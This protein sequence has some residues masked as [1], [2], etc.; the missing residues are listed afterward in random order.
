MTFDKDD[1][2]RIST[3]G[4]E[5]PPT[6]RSYVSASDALNTVIASGYF[7]NKINDWAVNDIVHI[8]ASDG[9]GL[10]KVTS[11]TTNVT[12]EAY[13]IPEG[14]LDLTEGSIFVGDGSNK[15][16]ELDAKADAQLLL[17][18]GT[19]LTSVAMSGD[20]NIDNAGAATIQ[21][22]AVTT[23]KILDA[24][25][26]EAKVAPNSLTGTVAGNVGDDSIIGGIPILFKIATDGGATGNKDITMTHKV[27]ILDVWSVNLAAGTTSDTVQ[28]FNSTNAI[29]NAMDISGVDT[30]LVRAATIDDANH[31]IAASGTLR[32]TET[33][34]GG[35]DSPPLAVYIL[36]VRVA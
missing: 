9:Y 10:Y 34:G 20:V 7:N 30:S 1:L 24:N 17:G 12:V 36:A 8:Q 15:A 32:V 3:S 11:V 5:R 13:D 2:A 25:V 33:D 27:R 29:T 26:T 4:S 6:W 22:D 18:N 23:S 35:A 16:V 21:S 19:T 28:V 31:E 14:N